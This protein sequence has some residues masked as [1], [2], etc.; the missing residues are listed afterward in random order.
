MASRSVARCWASSGTWRVRHWA[1]AR[2]SKRR[3]AA[4]EEQVALGLGDGRRGFQ[5]WSGLGPRAPW[6]RAR[7][8]ISWR[9]A[10]AS[11][12]GPEAG[13]AVLGGVAFG[14]NFQRA[15]GRFDG[16]IIAWRTRRGIQILDAEAVTEFSQVA[17]Q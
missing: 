12:A 2:A 14:S 7:A 10:S 3:V 15:D 16:A 13:A 11:A 8:L 1:G 9:A 6:G 4:V 17:R 5:T